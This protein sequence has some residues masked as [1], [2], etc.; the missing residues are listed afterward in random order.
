MTPPRILA[1]LF[2]RADWASL[3]QADILAIRHD[4]DCSQK[5]NGR[6]FAPM[7]DSIT[8]E[9][10]DAKVLTV[11]S[12][13]SLWNGRETHSTALSLNS[14]FARELLVKKLFDLLGIPRSAS[15]LNTWRNIVR[16]VR[17]KYAIGVQP[18]PAFCRACHEHGVYVFEVQHGY[19]GHRHPSY[20]TEFQLARDRLDMVDCLLC[21]D[22]DAALAVQAWAA[23]KNVEVR[24]IGNPWVNR[25]LLR[26][27][28]D[29]ARQQEPCHFE[30]RTTDCKPRLLVSLQW[31]LDDPRVTPDQ[32]LFTN[33]YLPKALEQAIIETAHLYRWVLKP[34]PVQYSD[35]SVLKHIKSYVSGTFGPS[36]ELSDGTALPELL[37]KTDLHI[38]YN[39][40]VV[41]EAEYFG[42]RS[43][44]LDPQVREGLWEGYFSAQIDRGNAELVLCDAPSISRWIENSLPRRTEPLVYTK[45]P[46]AYFDLINELLGL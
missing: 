37:T 5:V 36:V 8:D 24:V 21:W 31:G 46:P 35:A 22:D 19:I 15:D 34:H 40:S 1:Q 39:S 12:P 6:H 42:I 7:I 33:A 32:C 45:V 3:T 14:A 11:A 16:L 13:Y 38:T 23:A 9:L 28:A 25:F 29:P 41:I 10:H 27:K 44:I 43:C 30:A 17:P 26:G 18:P 4:A 20:S 2:R